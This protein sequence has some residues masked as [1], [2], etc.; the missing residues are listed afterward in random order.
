MPRMTARKAAKEK[1]STE[2]TEISADARHI[3][4]DFRTR[5]TRAV[6]A[7]AVL[8]FANAVAANRESEKPRAVCVA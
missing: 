6:F 4:K 8:Y 3:F 1:L 2:V 5:A 7:S